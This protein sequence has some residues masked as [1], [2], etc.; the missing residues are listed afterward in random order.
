[1]LGTGL[2]ELTPAELTQGAAQAKAR[3]KE[4]ETEDEGK[5]QALLGSQP[6]I[7]RPGRRARGNVVLDF[8]QITG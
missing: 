2:M 6:H 7:L 3:Q 4:H 5:S 8:S 1:M